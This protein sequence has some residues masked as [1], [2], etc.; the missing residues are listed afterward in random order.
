MVKREK[1]KNMKKYF[2]KLPYFI[3]VLMINL[4]GY[5]LFRKRYPLE[6]YTQL[7]YYLEHDYT[8]DFFFDKNKLYDQLKG[9]LFYEKYEGKD[10]ENFPIIN[11]QLIK[12]KYSEIINKKEVNTY[13]YTSGTT[14][15]GLTFPISKEFIVNQWAVF[16]KFRNIHHITKDTWMANITSQT[17][18]SIEQSNPP[19]WIKSYTTK[20]L[21]LSSYHIKHENVE[22][23]LDAIKNNKI[24]WLHAFPSI[25]NELANLIQE[26][27]LTLK[28]RNLKLKVITTSSEKLF[29]YQKKN[30]E[31][32]FDCKVRE[33]YGQVEGVVN[34]FECEKG[35]LHIDE[36][37]SYVELIPLED[38]KE[39]RIVGTS[40]YNKAFPLVRY[41]TNDT[42]LL[43]ENDF[44]CSCGRKSRI[45]KEI[46]GRADDYILLSDGTKL[47]R[48]SSLFKS[49]VSIKEAQIFQ[50]KIGYAEF[51]IVKDRNYTDKD[52]QV[53]K[54][55]IIEKLGKD[56]IFNIVY[57]NS[58]KK[59]KSGKLKLVINN[60]R[61]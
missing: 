18:F 50:D 22:L 11:K 32:I 31:N 5:L 21:L 36:K 42:C 19:Y 29:E 49:S 43:Y 1:A 54:N 58:I 61:A 28:A 59:T 30:I 48:L 13:L 46:L 23:Y 7:K 34:I 45:V 26:Q 39:Y 52:E 2:I 9:S 38:N 14:G 3:K 16:W 47:S 53:L 33:L 4:Y 37:Y 12:N 10:I 57:Y 20:Q 35:T 55:K 25:L 44:K 15:S 40:Y 51:R 27:N 24:Y 8:E 56:F 17:L 60:I 6:F 41:D